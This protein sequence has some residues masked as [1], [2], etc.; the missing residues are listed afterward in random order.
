MIRRVLFVSLFF[1][2]A[3]TCMVT[4]ADL[5][6]LVPADASFV[7][8]GN[9]TKLFAHA[10]VKNFLDAE[11]AKQTPDEK[12]RFEEFKKTTGFDPYT[13]LTD[14][15][16]YVSKAAAANPQEF[17]AVL[18]TGKFDGT[19]LVQA[20]AERD[21]T[22]VEQFEG[23][24]ALKPRKGGD[25]MLVVLDANTLV[26][27]FAPGV[28]KVIEVKTGKAKGIAA[29]AQ[30]AGMLKKADATA[31]LWGAGQLPEE[32]KAQ[33]KKD[34][35]APFLADSS[36]ILFSINIDK[37]LTAMFLGE[38]AKPEA[39]ETAFASI[40]NFLTALKPMIETNKEAGDLLKA[41]K[42]EKVAGGVKVVAVLTKD[43]VESMKKQI[44]EK[45]QAPAPAKK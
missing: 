27:G 4:A 1:V 9:L 30:F 38:F 29:D 19:K 21:Q 11:L 6:E 12:A 28:K 33:M 16:L 43:Q 2:F 37:E 15:A 7:I 35:P 39:I 40:Q 3:V 34:G 41:V 10:S 44:L 31:T 8:R 45:A 20:M 14:M 17:G 26:L 13:N 5:V 22:A 24:N 18:F 42:A 32:V 36:A 25:E 23:C